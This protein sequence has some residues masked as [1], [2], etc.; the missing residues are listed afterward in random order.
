MAFPRNSEHFWPLLWGAAGLVLVAVLVLEVQFGRSGAG[1]GPRAPAK[2]AEAKLLPAFRLS[3]EEQSG[4]ET[5]SRPLF[6]PGRRQAPPAAVADSGSMKKG[7][8]LLQGTTMVGDLAFAMLKENASGRIHRVQKGGKVLDM[9]LSEVASTYAVLTLGSDSETVPLLVARSS[10]SAA[11][12]AP[13]PGPFAAP[14]PMGGQPAG[15]G[16]AQQPARSAQ[17]AQSTQPVRPAQPVRLQAP[18]NAAGS[19]PSAAESRQ[20]AQVEAPPAASVP[21]EPI[22]F[23]ELARRRA[24]RR[25]S[26]ATN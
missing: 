24:A 7:Q 21:N 19:T 2:V 13:V 15:A 22:T 1:E 11:A 14:A 10:S 25:T 16:A 6:A 26:G 8:F 3:A 9:T 12:Q 17:S 23:E 18:A 20:A 4:A 5:V